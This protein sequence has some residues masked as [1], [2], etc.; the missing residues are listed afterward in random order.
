MAIAEVMVDD[1]AELAGLDE[2]ADFIS[3]APHAV[4]V[5]ANT[6]AAVAAIG[7]MTMWN[8]FERRGVPITPSPT[9]LGSARRAFGL[10]PLSLNLKGLAQPTTVYGVEQAFPRPGKARGIEGMRADD[11]HDL[12]VEQFV[13]ETLHAVIDDETVA[14][15]YD[16]HD[17]RA[18]FFFPENADAL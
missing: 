4:S 18:A 5:S 9:K 6:A 3:F 11:A 8:S 16:D 13:S 1:I 14:A 2:P 10:A 7:L 15:L 12:T 17:F